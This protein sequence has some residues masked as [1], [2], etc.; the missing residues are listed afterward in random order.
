[1]TD[2]WVTSTARRLIDDID[3]RALAEEAEQPHS[4]IA[5]DPMTQSYTVTGPYADAR[6]AT[7]EAERIKV[8]LNG[9][10]GHPDYP[11]IQT[12]IAMHFP[13]RTL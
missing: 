6:L 12:W 2:D 5:Y 9:A 3:A 11:P 8:Q 1:M 7:L 4:V 13:P 10:A